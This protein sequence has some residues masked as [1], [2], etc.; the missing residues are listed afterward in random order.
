MVW[1]DG[2]GSYYQLIDFVNGKKT[3]QE[4]DKP[5]TTVS[6]PKRNLVFEEIHFGNMDEIEQFIME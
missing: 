4:D 3:E 2:G 1:P 6:I 5:A